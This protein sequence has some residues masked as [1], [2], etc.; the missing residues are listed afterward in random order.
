V[1]DV[2]LSFHASKRAPLSIFSTNRNL[3]QHPLSQEMNFLS[4]ARI[5]LQKSDPQINNKSSTPIITPEVYRE[6]LRTSLNCVPYLIRLI[7]DIEML[8]HAA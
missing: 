2:A 8:I 4:L 3:G 7:L 5:S 6:K 1:G